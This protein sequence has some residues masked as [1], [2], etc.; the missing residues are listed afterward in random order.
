MTVWLGPSP[1]AEDKSP[2]RE[3]EPE[4]AER[5]RADRE[6]LARGAEPAPAGQQLALL[7]GER[8]T[9]PLLAHRAPRAKAEIEVVEDF[10][11]FVHVN[12]LYSLPRPT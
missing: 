10:G 8:L 1:A 6:R 9:P 12:S 3:A 2:K 7:V 11:R 5:E 4:R